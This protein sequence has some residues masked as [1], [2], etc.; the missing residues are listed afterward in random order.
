[1]TFWDRFI[2]SG[3]K[4][5]GLKL[6]EVLL[7]QG[8]ESIYLFPLGR[9]RILYVLWGTLAVENRDVSSANN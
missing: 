6:I 1:M 8:W 3:L 4:L 9:V 2:E 7:G 5:N